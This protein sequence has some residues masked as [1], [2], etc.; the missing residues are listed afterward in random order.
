[1][2][3]P[4]T[5]NT[6]GTPCEPSGTSD[7]DRVMPT[8]NEAFF[9]FAI[10]KHQISKPEINWAAVAAEVGFKNGDTAKVCSCSFHL[11]LTR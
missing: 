9:F 5:P 10:L 11:P 6:P 4:N 2:S 7:G 1:M 3:T 8:T